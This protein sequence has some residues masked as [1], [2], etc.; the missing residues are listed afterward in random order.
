VYLRDARDYG[1]L[2]PA[3]RRL[4]KLEVEP[5]VLRA[6]ICRPELLV[7]IEGTYALE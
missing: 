3:V 6:D 2:L 7:E 5:L 1:R 4:F